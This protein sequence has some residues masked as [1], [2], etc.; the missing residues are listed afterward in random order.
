MH[1][2]LY[3][4]CISGTKHVCFKYRVT[5]GNDGA[6]TSVMDMISFKP[7]YNISVK[8]MIPYI[9]YE[10]QV[11]LINYRTNGNMHVTKHGY[12]VNFFLANSCKHLQSHSSTNSFY[13]NS[14]HIK[15]VPMLNFANSLNI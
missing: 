14:P 15:P 9:D 10:Y 1:S 5:L 4:C 7:N 8:L 11:L 13:V 3:G 12:Q 6:I 2:F